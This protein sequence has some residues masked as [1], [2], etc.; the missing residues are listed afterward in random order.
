MTIIK[1]VSHKLIYQAFTVKGRSIVSDNNKEISV[2][3]LIVK[4]I[5][6]LNKFFLKNKT[7]EIKKK[8]YDTNLRSALQ[9]NLKY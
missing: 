4:H 1:K 6:N 2:I 7:K 5:E 8:Y 9:K 3:V